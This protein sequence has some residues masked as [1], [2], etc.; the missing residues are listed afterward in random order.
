MVNLPAQKQTTAC[1]IVGGG[2][3]GAVLGLLLARQGISVRLLEMH[4]DFDRDFRGDTLQPSVLEVMDEIGLAD[5]LLKLAYAK[6]SQLS[7]PSKDGPIQLADLRVLRT[8][9]PYI[10]MMPQTRFLEFVTQ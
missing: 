10:A 1:V 2:P 8:H 7:T 6:V 9:F 4:A 3:A 5:S